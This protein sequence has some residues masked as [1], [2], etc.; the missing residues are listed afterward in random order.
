LTVLGSDVDVRE[1]LYGQRRFDFGD[2][3]DIEQRIVEGWREIFGG[4]ESIGQSDE[5][6][7]VVGTWLREAAVEMGKPGEEGGKALLTDTAEEVSVGEESEW[8]GIHKLCSLVQ[9]PR[10]GESWLGP[11]NPP[12]SFAASESR[13]GCD[14]LMQPREDV[15]S[16]CALSN[17]RDE[18]DP[19]AMPSQHHSPVTTALPQ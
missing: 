3:L 18:Q 13:Q 17:L 12:R 6:G 5:I 11:R 1:G 9:A 19:L 15:S 2:C 16:Y 8:G 14:S 4:R 7:V 10:G